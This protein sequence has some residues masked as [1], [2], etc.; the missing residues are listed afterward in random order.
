M[1]SE[2]LDTVAR[3][4]VLSVSL[5]LAGCISIWSPGE[6]PR[7]RELL[8]GGDRLVLELAQFRVANGSYPSEL[9]GIRSTVDLG[10]PGSDF[11]FSYDREADSYL[12]TLDYTPSWPQSGRVSCS[13]RHDSPGWGC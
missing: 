11:H 7:G 4:A 6:D 8:E 3:I 2:D 13:R 5:S 12:L 10:R 9:A 1:A